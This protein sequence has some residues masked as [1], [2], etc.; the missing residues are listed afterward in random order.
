MPHKL[1]PGFQPYA[2]GDT[3][4]LQQLCSLTDL[5]GK[6]L[7]EMWMG[8]HPQSPS[9][10]ITDKREI[11]LNEFIASASDS[12]LGKA[13]SLN[14][15]QLP[16]LLKILAVKQ[17]LSI[18]IH[19]DKATAERGYAT[20]NAR[21]IALDSPYRT[22]KDANHKPELL[23]ALTEFTMM[24]GFKPYGDIVRCFNVY[25]VEQLWK[26]FA[27][28]S[29]K[30][31]PQTL[32]QLFRE[33]L[34]SSQE[35]LQCF[36]QQLQSTNFNL[37]TKDLPIFQLCQVLIEQYALDAGIVAPML[38]NV[39]TLQPTQA[40]FLPAGIMHA[41]VKG[42]G[43]E[44]MAN[45][46]NVIRG[47]LTSKNI[48]HAQLFGLADFG[49][50]VPDLTPATSV[51]AMHQVYHSKAAEFELHVLNL[52]DTYKLVTNARPQIILCL[53]GA[54]T[55]NEVLSIVKGEAVFVGANETETLLSGQASLVVATVP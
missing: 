37:E 10:L 28:F 23:C 31:S 3:S 46:D 9:L 30:Q 5:L 55:C 33:I 32:K 48:D 35:V 49:E 25:G 22:F 47:G 52:M 1:I 36:V 34:G 24:C 54:F 19:P 7:A 11:S 4:Y 42:V 18:Q 45:S 39:L 51:D 38:L 2:W 20:E 40:I 50:F 17:A 6:P 13:Y 12:L 8:A 27:V 43:I 26:G 21:G 14:G 44:L 41:Y 15:G 29:D 53:E 16:Y